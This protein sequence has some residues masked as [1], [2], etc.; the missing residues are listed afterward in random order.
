MS[1]SDICVFCGDPIFH[2]VEE[3]I[4][5]HASSPLAHRYCMDYNIAYAQ[6]RCG[7]GIVHKNGHLYIPTPKSSRVQ[8]LG[9]AEDRVH[10]E[11]N[12]VEKYDVQYG[13]KGVV[14]KESQV[15][16][17][18][19]CHVMSHSG[20]FPLT[21]DSEMSIGWV[22]HNHKNGKLCDLVGTK[23]AAAPWEYPVGH[24][25]HRESP[26]GN[27]LKNWERRQEEKKL[28][29]D[30]G[31]KSESG[32][33]SHSFQK[34]SGIVISRDHKAPDARKGFDP[35]SG[36]TRF[37]VETYESAKNRGAFTGSRTDFERYSEVAR[38]NMRDKK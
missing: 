35:P 26:D 22:H 37:G 9:N 8:D 17:E 31:I 33:T 23:H 5:D 14:P 24:P 21:K 28:N 6:G 19:I 3:E 4:L 13:F 34:D 10:R 30:R 7:G 36:P 18:G 38:S 2:G 11:F 12:V 1:H 27:G 29:E 15:R 16:D 25:Y 32:N 20:A